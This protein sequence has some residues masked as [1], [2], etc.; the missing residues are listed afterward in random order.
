MFSIEGRNIRRS[1]PFTSLHARG[2]R[3]Q[4]EAVAARTWAAAGGGREGR[5]HVDR[6]LE[7]ME[8]VS[9]EF[10][11]VCGMRCDFF[12]FLYFTLG[13]KVMYIFFTFLF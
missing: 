7:E 11:A 2:S 10:E 1:F 5:N 6:Y 3:L 13:K 9:V 12:L 4:V 8:C